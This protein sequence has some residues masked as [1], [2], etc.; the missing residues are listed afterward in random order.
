MPTAN[1]E[2]QGELEEKLANYPNGIYLVDFEFIG[3]NIYRGAASLG[4]NPHY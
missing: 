3:G 2:I 4:T 1:L